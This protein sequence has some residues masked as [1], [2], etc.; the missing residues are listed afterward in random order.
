MGAEV[1]VSVS[2][3]CSFASG[4][5]GLSDYSL[6]FG[7]EV[8][9]PCTPRFLRFSGFGLGVWR[10]AGFLRSWGVSGCKAIWRVERADGF[11]KSLRSLL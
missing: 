1:S 7:V 10:F 9:A 11:R 6:S 3:G 8:L 2:R 5:E 4:V